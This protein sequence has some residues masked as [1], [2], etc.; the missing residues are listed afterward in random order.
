MLFKRCCPPLLLALVGC[1]QGVDAPS[2]PPTASETRG[3]DAPV[4]SPPAAVAEAIE[5]LPLRYYRSGEAIV[6]GLPTLAIRSVGAT[7]E[8]APRHFDRLEDRLIEAAPFELE[9]VA[10]D[11]GQ[12]LFREPPIASVFDGDLV[13]EHGLVHEYFINGEDSVEQMWTFDDAPAGSG[14]LEIRVRTGGQSYVGWDEHGHHFMD[15]ATGVGIRY[16]VATWID[17]SGRETPVPVQYDGGELI[18]IVAAATIE[19]SVY[20]AILDP[21]I[22]A[23]VQ[24]TTSATGVG[25]LNE[26][27]PSLAFDGTN[28]FAVWADLRNASSNDIWG[29]RI[30]TA[31]TVL[32]LAAVPISIAEFDQTAPSIAF[33]G[34]DYLV[35]WAD[36]R[37]GNYDVRATRVNTTGVPVGGEFV[38]SGGAGNQEEPDV[39]RNGTEWLVAWEDD[40]SGVD[41]IRFA[42]VDAAG[43]PL[44]AGTLVAGGAVQER[45]PAAACTGATCLIAWQ[46]GATAED[47]HA[48]RVGGGAVLDSPNLVVTASAGRDLRADVAWDGTN[49][50]TTWVRQ[51][52]VYANRVSGAGAVLDGGGFQVQAPTFARQAPSIAFDGAQFIIVWH[53]ARVDALYDLYGARVQTTGVVTDPNGF[54]VCPNSGGQQ[55][56]SLAFGT[57]QYM[58]VWEDT[59]SGRQ[60]VYG[61]R[62]NTNGTSANLIGTVVARSAPRQSAPEMVFD[63]TRYFVV[64]AHTEISG[65]GAGNNNNILAVRVTTAG[66]V[67]DFNGGRPIS[68]F[69]GN[70]AAPDIAY[71]AAPNQFLIVWADRRNGVDFDVYGTRVSGPPNYVVLDGTGIA[72]ST[73]AEDQTFPTV[74]FNTSANRYMVAWQDRRSG[75]SFDIM[76]KRVNTDG[77]LADADP[78]LTIS[79]AVDDQRRPDIASNGTDWEVVWGDRRCGV[80]NCEDI[81]GSRVTNAP[82]VSGNLA[83]IARPNAQTNVRIVWNGTDYFA[84]WTDTRNGLTNPDIFGRR[85]A[86]GGAPLPPSAGIALVTGALETE[87]PG[88]ALAGAAYFLVWRQAPVA[89]MEARDL[90]GRRFNLDGTPIEAAAFAISTD[91]FNEDEP[92]VA[93]AGAL[94]TH[95]AYQ[96]FNTTPGLNSNRVSLRRVTFP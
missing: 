47:I 30:N 94:E 68:T 71:G 21:T 69:T 28:F 2:A 7:V 5:R 3:I 35:A 51:G 20:P 65:A 37:T 76:A 17:G 6:A 64:F 56:P 49:W 8:F 91:P 81:Y 66:V 34:T 62:I 55:L 16:G 14:D 70:Q 27:V 44:D 48:A 10:I 85:I 13:I 26:T 72:I 96:R 88:L 36:R 63:G 54:V 82:V 59:R 24:A 73:G 84:A 50:M 75:T 86:A 83:I 79:N 9:T 57:T 58:V 22:F 15:G 52:G 31:G 29:A 32:D 92:T 40:A 95:V 53:D 4:V 39:T 77:T 78:G 67:Q 60:D 25:A 38:L 18:L 42:R 80:L 41:N 43:T 12:G 61:T 45:H 46:D 74:A 33:N 23:E 87:R 19:S 1:G 90:F 89:G 11:R 93:A